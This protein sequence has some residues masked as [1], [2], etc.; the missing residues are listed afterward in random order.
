MILNKKPRLGMAKSCHYY[1]QFFSSLTVVKKDASI[2]NLSHAEKAMNWYL[3]QQKNI[4]SI[5][6]SSAGDS[7]KLKFNPKWEKALIEDIDGKSLLVAIVQ[8]NL[9]RASDKHTEFAVIIVN[10]ENNY[11]Y[12][13]ASVKKMNENTN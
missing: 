4:K 8:T 6:I 10:D 3:N 9:R 13:I 1:S 2:S 11:D 5:F 12:K 7:V